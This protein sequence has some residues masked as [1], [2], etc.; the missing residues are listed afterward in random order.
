MHY[1]YI[2]FSDKLEQTYTGFTTDL[3]RR[4][5]EH[6]K[7]PT[8][9]TVRADDWRLIWSASFE[10]INLAKKFEIYLKTKSG[11]AFMRKRLVG[12]LKR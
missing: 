1:C 12:N 7:R 11:R 6:R 5:R 9:T 4:L 3:E 8:K 2:L 10:N